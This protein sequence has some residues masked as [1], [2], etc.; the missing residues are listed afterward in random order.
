[1]GRM[2][3]EESN[4]VAGNGLRGAGESGDGEIGWHCRR[5]WH[6]QVVVMVIVEEEEEEEV[7]FTRGRRRWWSLLEKIEG[8]RSTRN[9]RNTDPFKPRPDESLA[10][11]HPYLQ[12]CCRSWRRLS[13]FV[14][15]SQMRIRQTRIRRNTDPFKP[16]IVEEEAFYLRVHR[17]R[18]SA[19]R[20]SAA[21]PV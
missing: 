11:C 4:G 17:K 2:A 5:R 10:L 12:L 15:Q 3:G 8:I 16:Q 19:R 13:L 14:I 7:V 20:A 18:G 1:M 9:T 6:L 21:T